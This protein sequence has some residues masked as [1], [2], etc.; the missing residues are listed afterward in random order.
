MKEFFE[1]WLPISYVIFGLF[2]GGSGV[3][4]VYVGAWMGEFSR[5]RRARS[6]W[7][8]VDIAHHSD[9]SMRRDLFSCGGVSRHGLCRGSG[10]DSPV[11]VLRGD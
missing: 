2:M 9:H 8:R 7:D 4:R 3:S 5:E 1:S 6:I 11:W 10:I